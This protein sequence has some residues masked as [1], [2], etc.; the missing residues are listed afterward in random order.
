MIDALTTSRCNELVRL[1]NDRNKIRPDLLLILDDHRGKLK[2][3]K[4]LSFDA[5]DLNQIQLLFRI[6]SHTSDLTKIDL[7]SP[8]WLIKA[9]RHILLLKVFD[10]NIAI[11]I[12]EEVSKIKIDQNLITKIP[13][14][15]KMA[16]KSGFAS[17]ADAQKYLVTE[18]LVSLCSFCTNSILCIPFDNTGDV[19][20]RVCLILNKE[21]EVFDC[22]Q[23]SLISIDELD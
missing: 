1:H 10:K 14:P 12:D 6:I 9:H 20:K 18:K 13:N 8:V 3:N 22:N 7:E 2:N 5:N 15:S 4:N 23:F 17:L 11:D 16:H 19:N 21:L